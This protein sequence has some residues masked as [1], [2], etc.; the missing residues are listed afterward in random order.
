MEHTRSD[1]YR[2]LSGLIRA[3]LRLVGIMSDRD[4]ALR[5]DIPQTTLGRRLA[6]EPFHLDELERLAALCGTT[7][8]AWLSRLDAAVAA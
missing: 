4:A 6:G 2:A 5:A 3:D 7:A 8:A 1:R